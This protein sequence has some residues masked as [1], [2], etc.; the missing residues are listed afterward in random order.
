VEGSRKQAGAAKSFEKK[1]L[2]V[3]AVV[4]VANW[5]AATPKQQQTLCML[6]LAQPVDH[7]PCHDDMIFSSPSD[8]AL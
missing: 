2:W 5:L 7:Q 8:Q 4:A 6:P 3:P 1:I